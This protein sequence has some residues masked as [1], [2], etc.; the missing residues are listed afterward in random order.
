ML[1]FVLY[2]KKKCI[3][4]YISFSVYICDLS[5]CATKYFS[6]YFFILLKEVPTTLQ[7]IYTGL[8]VYIEAV[9]SCVNCSRTV[10]FNEDISI[11]SRGQKV[12]DKKN[13]RIFI[14]IIFFTTGQCINY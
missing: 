4:V 3:K 1:K 11:T 5:T 14:G 10:H 2:P 13:S 6:Y 12:I 8:E 7:F 9:R